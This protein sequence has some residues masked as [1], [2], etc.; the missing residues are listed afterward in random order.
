MYI[1]I[2]YIRSTF[3]KSTQDAGKNSILKKFKTRE[4]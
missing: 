3:Q 1:G 2:E 4:I